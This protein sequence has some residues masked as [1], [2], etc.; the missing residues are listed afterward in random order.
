MEKAVQSWL[1]DRTSIALWIVGYSVYSP[2]LPFTLHNQRGCA[3]E[4]QLC[5]LC[6]L[7]PFLSG[8]LLGLPNERHLPKTG[9]LKE[10]VMKAFISPAP[11]A[12]GPRTRTVLE[13]P[14]LQ[15]QLFPHSHEY[16]SSLPLQAW[17]HNTPDNC[18]SLWGIS[19]SFNSFS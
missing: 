11:S 14:P 7:D 16:P 15:L 4:A 18:R 2:D 5:G 10:R 19:P 6:Q 17:S 13:N 8:F 3:P 1:N 12:L 9:G